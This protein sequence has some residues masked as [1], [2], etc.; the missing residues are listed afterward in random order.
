MHN[1]AS[2]IRGWANSNTSYDEKLCL[3]LALASMHFLTCQE[4]QIL[5][6]RF[7]SVEE[8]A[9]L[10]IDDVSLLIERVIP[11]ATWLGKKYIEYA[12]KSYSRLKACNIGF[13]KHSDEDYPVLLNEIYNKPYILFYR[14]C[15]DSLKKTSIALVGTRHPT[16]KGMEAA[17]NLARD[18]SDNDITV[19]SGLALGIDSF[20]HKGALVGKSGKTVAVLASGVDSI[21]PA[22]NARLAG[23]ILRKGGAFVSEYPPGE[24]ALRWHFPMRN[25]IISGLSNGTVVVEAPGK[26]G[27]LITADYAI[28]QNRELMFHEIAKEFDESEIGK[29]INAKK[30]EKKKIFTVSDYINDGALVVK[31]AQSV[32]EYIK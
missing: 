12:R 3:M 23:E 25:R 18:L 17:F 27:A 1:M 8:L 11:K 15:L 28:E 29:I 10:N 4:K 24:E 30:A 9:A 16:R 5:E 13:V 6:D 7:S 31:N 26:S 21:Y 22:G 32:I 20:S 19:V 14:G 2:N